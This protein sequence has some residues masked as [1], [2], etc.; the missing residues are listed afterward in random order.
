MLWGQDQ[1]SSRFDGL[2]RHF[3][4]VRVKVARHLKAKVPMMV[5]VMCEL[6]GSWSVHIA[7]KT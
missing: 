7:G 4:R 3:E 5:N 2:R 1:T 6:T